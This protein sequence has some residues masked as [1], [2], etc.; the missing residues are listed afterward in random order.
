[1]SQIVNYSAV[2]LDQKS[3]DVLK[4]HFGLHMPQEWKWI[5]H[6]MTICLGPLPEDMKG[7][8][9]TPVTLTVTDLGESDMA[10][11]VRVTGFKSKNANPHVTLAINDNAG[12]KAK[13]S[14]DITKWADVAPIKI[15]GTVEEVSK[16]AP[17]NEAISS[18][19]SLPFLTDV[20]SAGGKIYQVGG[21]V[22]DKFLGRDSKDLDILIQ[23]IPAET[24][25]TILKK[26]GKVDMVGA[27]FGIIKFKATG[28][29][30]EID[31]AIP[32]TERKIGPGSKGF[33]VDADHNLPVEKDL[34]RRDFTINS[35]A[36]DLDGNIIDPYD[37]QGDLKRKLIKVTNPIA[38][39]EDPVRMLR[40]VQFAARFGFTIVPETYQMI[41]DNAS[42]IIEEPPERYVIEFEKMV[43]KG[44]PGV[45]AHL[46]V[47]TGLYNYIFH[48]RPNVDYKETSRC[49]KLT[50]F[51]FML[52]QGT[53]LSPSAFFSDELKGDFISTKE[54]RAFE[55]ASKPVTDNIY[56]KRVRVTEIFNQSASALES[57]IVKDRF[58]DTINDMRNQK[59]PFSRKDL[60]ITGDDLTA[61]GLKDVQIGEAI[62]NVMA[63]VLQG[64]LNNDKVTL[65]QFIQSP[66]NEEIRQIK[67]RF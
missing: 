33:N 29:S 30:E 36:K 18:V 65:L 47:D 40:A 17:L 60:A 39:K 46:L 10:L 4:Q 7:Y 54:I 64:K 51:I 9:G 62:R 24:L 52:L 12:G 23:G 44:D 5:C 45:A 57:F 2:V 48:V 59:L 56:S 16:S 42:T 15:S 41:K 67:N 6:H 13:M 31:I 58:G 37:G 63:A 20:K 43:T 19:H 32:R 28:S 49:K 14:N 8:I 1:M 55:V 27:S 21:A 26:Y 11:A 50:E 35:I 22:R 66:L 53:S 38:F 34:E 25:N 61:I 3:R